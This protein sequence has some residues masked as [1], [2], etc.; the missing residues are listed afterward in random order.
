MAEPEPLKP[1]SVARTGSVQP[2]EAVRAAEDP[3]NVLGKFVRVER[4]GAGGMGEVWKA[5]DR[6]LRRWV[7]LKLLKST[8]PDEVLRFQREAQAAGKLSH[9]NIAAIYEVGESGGRPYIAMQFVPGRTLRPAAHGDLAAGVRYV[10]DAA[11]AVHHAHQCGIIHRDLKPQNIMVEEGESRRVFVLDFGLAKETAIESS[12][13]AS[14]C[15]L[16]TPAYMP[17][18]Q[19]MGQLDRVDARSDVYSL[20]ATLYEV[21]TG[22]PPFVEPAL[23]AL[24]QEVVHDDPVAPSRRNRRVPAELETIVLKCMEKDPSRRYAT[25]RELG[26]ELGRYLAGEAILAHRASI[27]YRLWKFAA[28]RRAILI[29]TAAAVVLGLVLLVWGTATW[30]ARTRRIADGIAAGR[31]AEE[32]GDLPAARDAYNAA[33]ALGE[34]PAA[35]RALDHV[36]ALLK[37]RAEAEAAAAQAM[38]QAR[39]DLE[40]ARYELDNAIRSLSRKGTTFAELSRRAAAARA[41]AEKAIQRVPTLAPAHELLGRAWQ[42]VGEPAKAEACYRAALASDPAYA[43]AHHYLAKLLVEEAFQIDTDHADSLRE[44]SSVMA[45]VLHHFAEAERGGF[46]DPVER[47]IAAAMAAYLGRDQATL[48][49]VIREGVARFPNAE[50]LHWLGSHGA[51][52]AGAALDRAIELRPAFAFAYLCRGQLRQDKGDL[53][54]AIEDFTA[55]VAW[56]PTLSEGYRLRAGIHRELKDYEKAR[57]DGETALRLR[58]GGVGALA[59]RGALRM[60]T[61]DL[62]GAIRDYDDAVAADPESATIR[63]GRAIARGRKGDVAGERAD[64]EVAVRLK[65]DEW[66]FRF[67]RAICRHKQGD[68]AG[69]LDDCAMI[70]KG[71][72]GNGNVRLWRARLRWDAGELLSSLEDLDIVLKAEPLNLTARVVRGNVRRQSD[73]LE[74]AMVDFNEALRIDPKCV[75]AL[76]DRGLLFVARGDLRSAIAD[77]D[78]ALALDAKDIPSL[79]NRGRARLELGDAP[80]ARDDFTR[81][82]QCGGPKWEHRGTI[83]GE[84]RDAQA[85]VETPWFGFLKA[86]SRALRRRDHDA[87]RKAFDAG[88]RIIVGDPAALDAVLGDPAKLKL[89]SGASYNLACYRAL[90]GEREAAVA[91]L[92][93]AIDLGYSNLD[94]MTKDPDLTSLQESAGWR[95]VVARLKRPTRLGVTLDEKGEITGIEAGSPAERAKLQVGGRVIEIAGHPVSGPGSLAYGVRRQRPGMKATVVVER[96]GE[97]TPVDVTLDARGEE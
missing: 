37:R 9:P 28:R 16:G 47:V 89:A 39:R 20:G 42:I 60:A 80:G 35:R 25:A 97:R 94:H 79:V 90:A 87:A 62:D 55:A 56:R 57:I 4:L 32:R 34:D 2:V 72:P 53:Q 41:H 76:S 86:G 30:S 84:L 85:E 3:G 61:G 63:N 13:S 15:V 69:A 43:P 46:D 58:P 14:G 77:F 38:E 8:S 48:R 23:Y 91:E 18:E 50:E 68:P 52:A 11:F 36:T 67:N 74:G 83:E 26:D 17:P 27:G 24:L 96:K 93:R 78:A 75:P 21:L 88:L 1:S 29:P 31:Q 51:L 73:D 10:R 49:V 54:S 7:A 19:A 71:H 44:R 6:D 95:E 5:W 59:E 92:H 33:L 40:P 70:L 64:L 65:P 66:R 22:G 12:L 81:A 82:L 45:E